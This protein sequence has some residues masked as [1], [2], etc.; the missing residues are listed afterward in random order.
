MGVLAQAASPG[1]RRG[2]GGLEIGRSDHQV[3]RS[4][5]EARHRRRGPVEDRGAGA[6][7]AIQRR[8]SRSTGS[9]SFSFGGMGA[10]SPVREIAW[11]RG[12]S[13]GFPGTTA[14]PE[15][16]PLSRPAGLSSLSP[17]LSFAAWAEWQRITLVDEHRPDAAISKKSTPRLS[18]AQSRGREAGEN[19]PM[20]ERTIAHR[21][22]VD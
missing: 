15:S 12:L 17:P 3:R 4:V 6:P 11:N 16:P 20:T 21:R 22:A 8:K 14:G 1:P 10:S 9:G 13:S 7:M 19:R 2:T 18:S 5:E